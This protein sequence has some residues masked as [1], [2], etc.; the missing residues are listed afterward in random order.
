MG[1]RY[2]V[3]N[4]SSHRALSAIERDVVD[5]RKEEKIDIFSCGAVARPL[6]KRGIHVRVET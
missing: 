4:K 6:Y 1:L 3:L 5:G 2:N